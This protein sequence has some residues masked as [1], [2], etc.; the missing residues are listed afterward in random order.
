MVVAK[1]AKVRITSYN[2]QG[3]RRYALI[4]LEFP[5]VDPHWTLTIEA[6]LGDL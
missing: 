1:V 3:Q 4:Y 5:L 6:D 2:G